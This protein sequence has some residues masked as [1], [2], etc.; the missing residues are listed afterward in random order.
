MSRLVEDKVIGES[1]YRVTQLGALLGRKV[2]FRLGKLL[3]P[4]M[5][6]I[7]DPGNL[8]R[9]LAGLD[10]ADFEWICSVM[11]DNTKLVQQSTNGQIE[12]ALSGIFDTHFA[13]KYPDMVKWLVFAVQ[14][15]FR[16]F[17]SAF[18]SGDLSALNPLKH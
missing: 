17:L 1:T 10:E 7:D 9:S 3:G 8:S 14:V 11:A 13:G 6:G 16:S 5:A 15:N 2:L 4:L 12:I 18:G